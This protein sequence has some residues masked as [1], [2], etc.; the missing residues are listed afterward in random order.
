MEGQVG[1][2]GGWDGISGGQVVSW[3]NMAKA[4]GPEDYRVNQ[5]TS[6]DL[7]PDQSLL[8]KYRDS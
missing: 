2:L 7:N 5:D 4:I 8:G 6:K 3:A 1:R